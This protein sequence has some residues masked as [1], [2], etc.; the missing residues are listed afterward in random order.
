MKIHISGSVAIVQGPSYDL[1]SVLAAHE[2][3]IDAFVDAFGPVELSIDFR[4]NRNRIG[5][6]APGKADARK[7]WAQLKSLHDVSPHAL[8]F[9]FKEL[10]VKARLLGQ[11]WCVQNVDTGEVVL[12]DGKPVS[13]IDPW[14]VLHV[15][16]PLRVS[17]T[18]IEFLSAVLADRIME[19]L[20]GPLAQVG[21]VVQRTTVSNARTMKTGKT[22]AVRI[23]F[24]HDVFGN[25]RGW[26]TVFCQ[27]SDGG[28]PDPSHV[29]N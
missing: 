13:K 2:T 15:V 4:K 25:G 5:W 3:V 16:G 6:P 7:A 20:R 23:I 8:S 18:E 19:I 11:T 9:S 29:E 21:L 12:H 1:S 26:L 10:T 14:P 28:E 17:G 24:P 27:S 22:D